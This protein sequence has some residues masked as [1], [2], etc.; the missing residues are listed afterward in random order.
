[1]KD[2]LIVEDLESERLRLQKIFS[3]AGYSVETCESV[4][5]AENFLKQTKCRLA[6]LDIGLGDKSGSHLFHE[7]RKAGSI[8]FLIIFT[9]N[10]S[11]HL[12]NRFITE[13]AADYIVKGSAQAQSEKLLARVKEIIGSSA[14][15]AGTEGLALQEL[16]NRFIDTKSKK[17]F[18]NMDGTIPK[19]S[20]C[21]GQEYVVTFAGIP[22]LP[23]DIAGKVKCQNC[24]TEMDPQIS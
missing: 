17:L 13:G 14:G 15:S 9:G 6:F 16:L 18:L 24:G 7:I 4:T 20:K 8:E 1:V 23:P 21:G 10:P 3:D 11:V 12:K 22:Q 19:C 5:D 2:I